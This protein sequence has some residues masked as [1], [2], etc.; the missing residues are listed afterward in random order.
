MGNLAVLF[1]DANGDG[2][3][4][5][6]TEA[7]EN[8]EDPEIIQRMYYYLPSSRDKLC[9]M[10]MQGNWTNTTEYQDRYTY[11]HKEQVTGLEWFAYGARYY[12]AKIGRFAGVDPLAHLYPGISPYAYVANNPINAIDP[13]GRYIIFIN[14]L[15]VGKGDAD[16]RRY[17]GGYKIHKTDV[18]DYWS[19][20]KNTFG[21]E[22][23]IAGYYQ[24]KYNDNNV[25]FTSGSSQ[26][27][28]SAKSRRRDGIRKAKL[29]HKMVQKGKITL[30]EGEIIK[31][32]SHSQGGAHAAGFI[33]QLQSYTDADGNPLYNIEAAE[34]ITPHQPTDINHPD[35][36]L[37][38]QYSHPSDAVSSDAPWWLP[39]GGSEYGRINGIDQFFGGD[40]MG[41][42]GQPPCGGASGNRCGHNV[43]D[44]DE[45]I[46]QGEGGN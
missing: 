15:R 17:M 16:Q 28:S 11:N 25:G 38:I 12:D 10:P 18:Y 26:W 45:F 24:K 21:R 5:S 36:V 34:Y 22:A 33:E 30:A 1:S 46:K 39:N 2:H 7:A 20:K 3:I 14:G 9:G 31:V 35:G 37:G 43:T 42:E 27:N 19:T 4:S 32:I 6:E 8:G 29:F 40:I 41:G 44:N 23:D 13:D